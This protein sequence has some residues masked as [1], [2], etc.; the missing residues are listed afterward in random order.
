MGG[1]RK[2]QHLCR[3]IQ[4][5]PSFIEEFLGTDNPALL[6]ILINGH[7]KFLAK[8]LIELVF[9]QTTFFAS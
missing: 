1:I 7:T 5:Q 4:I 9:V 6:I 2:T 8:P 3:C